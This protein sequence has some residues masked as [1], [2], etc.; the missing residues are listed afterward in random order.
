[1]GVRPLALISALWV[2]PA[3]VLR[4]AQKRGILYHNGARFLRLSEEKIARD[5][6][7]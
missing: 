6:E 1:V 4:E 3:P 7:G 5:H 2:V